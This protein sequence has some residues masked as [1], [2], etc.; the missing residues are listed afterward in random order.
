MPYI[1]YR[2]TN[3]SGELLYFILQKDFPHYLTIL[4]DTPRKTFVQAIP[5]TN[6]SL[7][8]VFAGVLRGMMIPSY[9]N[10]GEEISSVMQSMASWFF[11]NRILVDPKKY[12]KW[13]I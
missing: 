8:L 11:D 6:Y 2:D 9:N 10:V 13:K 1:T 5:I 7:Y 12:K 3:E 4:S